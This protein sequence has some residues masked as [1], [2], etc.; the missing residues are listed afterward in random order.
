MKLTLCHSSGTKNFEVAPRF[1]EN[2][3]APDFG[4]IRRC[5]CVVFTSFKRKIK[6]AEVRITCF[7]VITHDRMELVVNVF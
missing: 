7:Q 1:L 3:C 6:M 5:G 2:M 4:D